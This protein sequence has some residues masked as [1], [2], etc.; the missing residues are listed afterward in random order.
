MF[1][2]HICLAVIVLLFDIE[3]AKTHEHMDIDTVFEIGLLFR[4]LLINICLLPVSF[5]AI[6]TGKKRKTA[7]SGKKI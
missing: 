5:F 1:L 7:L 2:G 3:Y 4:I 6:R